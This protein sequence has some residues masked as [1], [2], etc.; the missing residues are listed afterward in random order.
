MYC[1]A[2]LVASRRHTPTIANGLDGVVTQTVQLPHMAAAP[3]G[4]TGILH[5]LGALVARD[6]FNNARTCRS[7]NSTHRLWSVR[8]SE[9]ALDL[10]LRDQPQSLG[11][12]LAEQR[13][14][15]P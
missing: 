1:N 13:C 11:S 12:T 6:R 8:T 5:T 4:V 7:K 10:D 15:Q 14:A 9:N 3:S 2:D